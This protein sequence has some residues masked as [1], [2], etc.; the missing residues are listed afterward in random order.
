MRKLFLT[1]IVLLLCMPALA[2]KDDK[3]FKTGKIVTL[4]MEITLASQDNY[5]L[6]HGDGR[7]AYGMTGTGTFSATPPYMRSY[8]VVLDTAEETITLKGSWEASGKRPDLQC[9]SEVQY[10]LEG[11]ESVRIADRNNR[12]FVFKVVKREP[13]PAAPQQ[14]PAAQSAPVQP[15]MP[16][17]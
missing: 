12:K 14:P 2:G 7:D 5:P 6:F 17:K 16:Q 8:L 15:V 13:K 1:I 10:H 11:S 4:Q 9:P 3:E